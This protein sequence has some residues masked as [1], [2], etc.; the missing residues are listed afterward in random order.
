[1]ILTAKQKAD[2]ADRYSNAEWELVMSMK[3]FPAVVD[4]LTDGDLAKADELV[5]Q[6]LKKAYALLPADRSELM[7]A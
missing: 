2:W 1:M 7:A 5:R 3:A 4:A 6:A